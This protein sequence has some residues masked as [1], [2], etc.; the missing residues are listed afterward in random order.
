VGA[1]FGNTIWVG[2]GK[3]EEG[4]RGRGEEEKR[5]RGEE[6]KRGRGKREEEKRE[7]TFVG[8]YLSKSKQVK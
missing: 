5:G 2:R 1:T 3:R 4:K 8:S 7:I 6:E